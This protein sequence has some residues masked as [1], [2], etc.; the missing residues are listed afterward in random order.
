MHFF[1]PD[2]SQAEKSGNGLRIFARYLVDAGYVTVRQFGIS[3]GGADAWVQQLDDAAQRFAITMGKVSFM[4]DDIPMSGQS[5]EVVAEG[6]TLGETP[7]RITAVNVGNP[8]CV[9]FSDDLA[10]ITDLGPVLETHPAFPNRTNV[11]LVQVL[12]PNTIHITIWERGAGYTLASGTSAC[13]TAAASVRNGFCRSPVTV[14]M[15]GG[16]AV[17]T[18]DQQW[19]ASLAG[20]VTAVFQ[21]QLADD[22]VHQ[23]STFISTDQ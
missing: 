6:I 1:N 9:I 17:V 21:G 15:K 23:L 2:G 8:H 14:Q 3:L 5:R 20:S 7:L 18:L 22:L 4:S 16:T 19:Q 13:A 11:Q 12:D 10:A